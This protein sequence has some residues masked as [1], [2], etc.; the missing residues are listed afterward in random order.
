MTTSAGWRATSSAGGAGSAS[1]GAMTASAAA[2][3]SAGS[4]STERLPQLHSSKSRLVPSAS[5]GSAARR[6]SPPGRLDLHDVGAEVAEQAGRERR[7]DAA[8][9]LDD[10]D[11]LERARH[12]LL[13]GQAR[14]RVGHRRAVAQREHAGRGARGAV[15]APGVVDADL[16]HDEA[17]PVALED[18]GDG[19]ARLEHVADVVHLAE[20]RSRSSRASRAARATPA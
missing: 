6:G 4:P 11:A 8:A 17:Q 7:G 2:S 19:A 10:P 5:R 16:A 3:S 15:L 1:G 12:G 9:Q 14:E 18:L 20:R 13:R